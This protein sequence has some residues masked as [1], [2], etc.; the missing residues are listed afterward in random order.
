MSWLV[1]APNTASPDLTFY[2]LAEDITLS[3][4]VQGIGSARRRDR[5][6]EA[7]HI[8][9]HLPQCWP[10]LLNRAM[11]QCMETI[12]HPQSNAF[13][14]RCVQCQDIG[15]RCRLHTILPDNWTHHSTLEPSLRQQTMLSFPLCRPKCRKKIRQ[16]HGLVFQH[17]PL[18]PQLIQ[19]A[20]LYGSIIN[21]G[22][23]KLANPIAFLID[24]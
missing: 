22:H 5:D 6:M 21:T 13:L 2:S 24:L 3:T 7:V 8:L 18:C 15:A 10:D 20:W 19:R 11:A 9:L 12:P 14:G 23:D 17:R 4:A 1:S 16:C